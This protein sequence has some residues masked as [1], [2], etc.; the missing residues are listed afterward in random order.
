MNEELFKART[1]RLALEIIGLV[2]TLPRNRV[3]DVIGRQLLRSGTS[4][5]SNYRAACRG[6]SKAD[7]IAKLG[8]VEEEADETMYWLDLLLETDMAD[9]SRVRLLLNETNE[10]LAMTVAS[11]KTLR[12]QND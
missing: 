5:G 2:E 11:I 1:R 7:V 3:A 6:K 4:I 9:A 10:I 12:G 8:I